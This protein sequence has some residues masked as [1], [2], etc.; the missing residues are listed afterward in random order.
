MFYT[1]DFNAS[2]CFLNSDIGFSYYHN[3]FKY[4]ILYK[5]LA[6]KHLNMFTRIKILTG[7]PIK[8]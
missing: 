8:K 7:L 4:L 2:R 3:F 6:P 5:Y 1:Y